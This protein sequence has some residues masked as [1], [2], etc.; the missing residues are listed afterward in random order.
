MGNLFYIVWADAIHKFRKHHPNRSDWKAT[1]FVFITW[2]HAL[3]WWIILLWFK[4]FDILTI[5]QF[6]I[7]IFPGKLLDSF[8]VFT[9]EFAVPFGI[10]NYFLI[11]HKHRYKRIINK[12]PLQDK[13][14][15]FIYS[16]VIA[17]SAFISAILYGILN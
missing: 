13:R 6:K 11:F 7:D 9:I 2:I 17:L 15:A 14:Y 4:Y 1:V 5:P 3:N 16:T 12:Y 8:L 10:L